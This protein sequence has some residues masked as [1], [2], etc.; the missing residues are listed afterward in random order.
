MKKVIT[1]NRMY[2]SNGRKIG[3][4]LAQELDIHY[5]DK[6]LLKLAG[7]RRDIPYEELVKVDEKRASAWIY[8][9]GET[10]QMEPQYRFE[11]I[12]DVL[13]KTQ[14][15]IIKELAEKEDCVIIGRCA[16][17]ILKDRKCCRSV[18]IYAP[19]EYRVRTIMERAATD[20]KNAAS[21][22]KRMDKQRK[23]YYNYYTDENWMDMGQYD[24][25]IDSSKFTI[26]EIVKLLKAMYVDMG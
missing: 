19:T 24:I 16:N 18:F 5:Y 13:F 1:V 22:I 20:E 7:E 2:G 14:T 11:P 15:E 3:K 21:L 4:A 6:E 23:Y 12:N 26:E 25:C 9:V 10:L 17:D 8:P